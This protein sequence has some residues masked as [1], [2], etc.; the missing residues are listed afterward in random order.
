MRS[1]TLEIHPERQ[2]KNLEKITVAERERES[3][4]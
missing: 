2:K 4:E 1:E 3:E